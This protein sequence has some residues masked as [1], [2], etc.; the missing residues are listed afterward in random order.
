MPLVNQVLQAVIG[1]CRQLG[2]SAT[3]QSLSLVPQS[4]RDEPKAGAI[5][6]YRPYETFLEA[7]RTLIGLYRN[8]E[9]HTA[10]AYLDSLPSVLRDLPALEPHRELIQWVEDVLNHITGTVEQLPHL[11]L[12][13][14]LDAEPYRNRVFQI[15][16]RIVHCLVKRRFL[17]ALL[18]LITLRDVVAQGLLDQLFPGLV[19]KQGTLDEQ[20]LNDLYIPADKRPNPNGLALINMKT[21]KALKRRS[22]GQEPQ[23]K[24]MKWLVRFYSAIDP[25]RDMRNK[26]VHGA[27]F[28]PDDR[29]SLLNLLYQNK[30][31][32]FQ[33]QP[34][35]VPW[36]D[37]WTQSA[38]EAGLENWFP[39]VRGC[40][41]QVEDL[42]V[43]A[44]TTLSIA[45]V[46]SMQ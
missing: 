13:A 10:G 24:G 38:H 20:K 26:L 27:V 29:L 35:I 17:D 42:A 4:E 12:A 30:L 31:D 36:L 40:W 6:T 3:A 33:R 23:E 5:Q 2:P 8:W 41:R 43:R 32:H 44:A 11:V 37:Q 1:A 9:F 14:G 19:S 16:M 7:R 45:D 34:E 21:L 25:T 22:K 46:T 39:D 15:Q 18:A 28:S